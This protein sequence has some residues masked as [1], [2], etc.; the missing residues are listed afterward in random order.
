MKL[1]K[2]V[3]AILR[4]PK[5]NLGNISQTLK[6]SLNVLSCLPW[7]TT[8]LL[9]P[10]VIWRF[11]LCFK[12]SPLFFSPWLATVFAHPQEYSFPSSTSSKWHFS[13]WL[14]ITQSNLPWLATVIPLP[15]RPWQ[16][17]RRCL[18]LS[19]ISMTPSSLFSLMVYLLKL[20]SSIYPCSYKVLLHSFQLSF[21]AKLSLSLALPRV[22]MFWHS[23][24]R[25]FMFPV[26]L[27]PVLAVLIS[28]PPLYIFF[29]FS[30]HFSLHW[31]HPKRT[32]IISSKDHHLSI[33]WAQ[34]SVEWFKISVYFLINNRQSLFYI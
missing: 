17:P 31:C 16:D 5:K 18:K 33:T 1:K 25:Y 10:L 22:S 21:P 24:S 9:K 11:L 13:I 3:L 27:T 28:G 4:N 29:I 19:F 23:H 8:N 14:T 20:I 6:I 7:I 32:V 12:S 30:L 34:L 26:P 15:Q 2:E